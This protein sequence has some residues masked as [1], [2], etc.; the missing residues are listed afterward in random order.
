MKTYKLNE[1]SEKRI[2]GRNVKDAENLSSLALFWGASALEICVKASEVWVNFSSDFDNSESWVCIEINGMQISRFIA[3][4]EKTWICVA[5]NLN[6]EKE[7]LISIIKDTQAMSSDEHHSLFINEIGLSDD[8]TFAKITPRKMK[9]EFIGDSITSG[10]GLAGGIDEMEWIPQWFCAS[11]TY[12]IQTAKALNADWSVMSQCGW[13]ICWGWDGNIHTAIPPHYENVCSL[14]WGEYQEKL[15]VLQKYDFGNGSDFVVINLGTNDNGAFFQ[16]AWKD[17]NGKEHVLHT[18][19]NGEAT[20]EDGKL[21]YEGVK[22]FL[23]NIRKHNP[24]S[25][26][27]WTWGMIRLTSIPKFI[28]NAVDDFKTENDDKNVF[29][30]E[31]DA[32]EDVEK[33]TEDKGS[34]GHPGPKTHKLATQKLTDFIKKL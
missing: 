23:K 2:L 24:N 27:I 1:I 33:L 9:I 32:M 26:I 29:T 22:S 15:G 34:R 12:A 17:E 21:V 5:R 25:K 18:N 7:N 11:K 30:L 28:Q 31:F 6:P 13:G 14:M 20:D 3:P 16:P 4:K 19:K 8:G 10:E